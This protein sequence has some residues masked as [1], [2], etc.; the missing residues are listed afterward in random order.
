MRM[1]RT[2]SGAST[3]KP[4]T[5]PPEQR[6]TELM[7]AAERLFLKQGVAPTTIEQITD[8]AGVA[9]GTFYLY[10]SSKEDILR[11]LGDRFGEQHL[12]TIKAALSNVP[13][14]DWRAK[15]NAWVSAC[16]NGYLDS[17]ELHDV[18]FYGF[19]PPTREGLVRNG[20]IDHL[21]ELLCEG[22]SA[23]AWTIE[24]PQLTAVFLFSGLH[25]VVDDAYLKEKKI[26]RARLVQK[27]RELIL[28]AMGPTVS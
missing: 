28:R 18:L 5:K 13:A 11:A 1:R 14:E 16:L 12:D 21:A 25:A 27:A 24:D 10:F 2:D 17:I 6:R 4:R 15:L 20:V 9:K 26:H 8:S 22:I 23:G 19:R 7:D 3:S